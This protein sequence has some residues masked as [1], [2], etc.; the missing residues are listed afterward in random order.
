[1]E[2]QTDYDPQD[3]RIL[4]STNRERNEA[5]KQIN[6]QQLHYDPPT[7][8]L[9]SQKLIDLLTVLLFQIIWYKNGSLQYEH[10]Y[11]FRS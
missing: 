3:E 1:M 6:N 7:K 11:Q 4:R 2:Q 9:G 10:R 5:Q 8:L